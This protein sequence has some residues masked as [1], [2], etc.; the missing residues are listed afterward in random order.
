MGLLG[1]IGL[2]GGGE[3]RK[4]S[5]RLGSVPGDDAWRPVGTPV[6][7]RLPRGAP[8]APAGL[9]RPAATKFSRARRVSLRVWQATQTDLLKAKVHK[10]LAS[11][12]QADLVDKILRKCF[13]K[14]YVAGKASID[15]G[16]RIAPLRRRAFA[17]ACCSVA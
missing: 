6:R 4:Q 9:S 17:P 15:T 1:W 7:V 10:E 5:D 14:C 12:Y 2:G 11:Q 8:L 13:D 3:E 16:D